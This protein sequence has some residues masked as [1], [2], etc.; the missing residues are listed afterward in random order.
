[1]KIA[2]TDFETTG[3]RPDW[4]EV[5]EIGVV[6]FDDVHFEIVDRFSA[7]IKPTYPQRLDPKAQACNGYTEEKW[8]DAWGANAAWS[9]YAEVTKGCVFAAHNVTFDWAF[10][11]ETI[12]RQPNIQLG[13]HYQKLDTLSM[14]YA[15]LPGTKSYSL[16]SV[17]QAL[18]IEPEP[19]VHS[20]LN[21]AM[22]GYEVFKELMHNI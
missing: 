19:E 12:K 21:G 3:L 13:L 16:K 14:A 7:K 8:K 1:M 2:Y 6:I 17:C 20:A 10:L 4:H 15:R 11:E 5:I 9:R 18:G 22:K